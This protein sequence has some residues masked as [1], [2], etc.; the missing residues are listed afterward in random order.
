M[1]QIVEQKA[2]DKLRQSKYAQEILKAHQRRQLGQQSR[3]ER[4]QQKEREQENGQLHLRLFFQDESISALR[5]DIF[6]G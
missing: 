5:I 2:K 1:L 3:E 6:I 4:Q